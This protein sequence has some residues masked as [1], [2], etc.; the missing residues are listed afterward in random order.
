TLEDVRRTNRDPHLLFSQVGERLG[1]I[2]EA[3]VRG[4]FANIW[5]QANREQAEELLAPAVSLLP[6]ERRT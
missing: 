3:T 6:T 4:A 5:A 1:L 2:P